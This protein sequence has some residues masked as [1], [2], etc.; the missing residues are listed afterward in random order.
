M[1]EPWRWDFLEL[2]E[3]TAVEW[4]QGEGDTDKYRQGRAIINF[5]KGSAMAND[6]HELKP[7]GNSWVPHILVFIVT[8]QMVILGDPMPRSCDACESFGAMVKK[9][10]GRAA[11]V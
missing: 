7:T 10:I 6:L 4:P 9:I 11:A 8:Q 5:N 2:V 3:A 1:R